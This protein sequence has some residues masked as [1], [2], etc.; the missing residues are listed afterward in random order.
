MP[1]TPTFAVTVTFAIGG[2]SVVL[3][4]PIAGYPQQLIN[5]QVLGRTAAGT[6]YVYDK[7]SSWFETQL[8]FEVS[9]AQKEAFEAWFITHA[10]GMVNTFSYTDHFLQTHAA[11]RLLTPTLNFDKLTHGMFTL[12]LPMEI[13][14]TVQ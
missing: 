14:N 4:A 9:E 10:D 5:N 7:G 2:D 13:P 12:N 6:A 11:C 8:V 1:Y 3:P